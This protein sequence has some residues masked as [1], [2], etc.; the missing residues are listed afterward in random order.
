MSQTW[1]GTFVE[2]NANVVIGFAINWTA[3]IA[4]LPILWNP[5]S[6]KLSS[7]Y[8][9]LAFTGISYLRQMAL[10]RWFNGMRF[11]NKPA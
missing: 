5:A 7:F 1:L 11:G 10:R 4:L 3:N 9:G 6:P 2:A 8:I